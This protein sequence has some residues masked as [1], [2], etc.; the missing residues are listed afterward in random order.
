M[1]PAPLPPAVELEHWRSAR[2]GERYSIVHEGAVVL[3][4]SSEFEARARAREYGWI[5]VRTYE[6]GEL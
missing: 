4:F 6:E 1:K 3:T 2:F 5:V